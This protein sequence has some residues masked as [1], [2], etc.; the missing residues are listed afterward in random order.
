MTCATLTVL[1]LAAITVADASNDR[2][3]KDLERL[4]GEWTMVSGR[5]DGVDATVD[6]EHPLHCT[7]QGDK[8]PFKRDGKIVEEVAIKLNPSKNPTQID[9]TLVSK[10]IAPGIYR[11][12]GTNSHSATLIPAAIGRPTSWRRRARDIHC[13]FGSA[14]RNDEPLGMRSLQSHGD[15]FDF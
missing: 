2:A 7:V 12:E 6:P 14:T 15:C 10:Q 11:L 8:V 5:Q 9:S 1:V 4:Q 3:K 13:P